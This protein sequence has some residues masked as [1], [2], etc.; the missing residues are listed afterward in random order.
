MLSIV[1]TGSEGGERTELSKIEGIGI[2][3]QCGRRL[4]L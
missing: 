2:P 3:R 1:R 4:Y